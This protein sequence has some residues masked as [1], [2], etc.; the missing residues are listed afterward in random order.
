M[1]LASTD[2]T[3]DWIAD[4]ALGTVQSPFL[5]LMTYISRFLTSRMRQPL[6]TTSDSR[7]DKE[8]TITVMRNL[9]LE[10]SSAGRSISR[11]GSPAVTQSTPNGFLNRLGRAVL[12]LNG[13]LVSAMAPQQPCDRF[14]GAGWHAIAHRLQEEGDFGLAGKVR[15]FVA[16]MP[17]PLTNR[18]SWRERCSGRAACA[19]GIRWRELLD[20][21]VIRSLRF[22]E[23]DAG[24]QR[25]TILSLK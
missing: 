6:A 11:Q 15:F 22:F 20:G 14:T 2:P 1:R 12:L 17:V 8:C 4:G 7:H 16:P 10:V 25:K 3:P 24:W 5:L 9:L 19:N 13:G 23:G 21:P 18:S